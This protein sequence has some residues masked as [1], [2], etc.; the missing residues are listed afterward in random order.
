[1][2]I[3][4]KCLV[5]TALCLLLA[6]IAAAAETAESVP[7]A[8]P[9]PGRKPVI[10]IR[11]PTVAPTDTPTA[12]SDPTAAPKPTNTPAPTRTPKITNTPGPTRTPKIT[13]TPESIPTPKPTETHLPV[14]EVT[15]DEGDLTVLSIPT[16][17]PK[18][19]ETETRLEDGY[20]VS[21]N[22]ASA[23]RADELTISFV[24]DCSVGD[25]IK[26]RTNRS[27]LTQSVLTNGED[28]LFSTVSEFF[29]ADDFT[30]ANLEVVLTDRT[31]PQYPA[32]AYNMI[33][34]PSF[35]NVLK[36]GGID[37]LNTVNNHC[38]DFKYGGYEDTLKNLEE[39]GL[40]H[41]GSLNPARKTNKYLDLGRI[42]IK[43]VR[44]GLI[45]FTYPT[46][47]NLTLIAQDIQTLRDEGCQIVIVS[48]HWG[49]EEH[50]TPNSTQ[51]PYAQAV[52]DAGADVIWGHHPHVLQPVYFHDGKPIFFSTGNFV[53]GSIKNLDPASG[54]FQLTWKVQENGEVQLDHFTMIPTQIRHSKL[55]Y[56]PLV[57]TD[58]TEAK[59]CLQHVIGKAERNGFERLPDG[60]A[61]T[62]T[63]YI[64]PDGQLS[65]EKKR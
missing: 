12:A 16:P 20:L 50:K 28:W 46:N 4:A 30:L 43:G 53:F 55:E 14:L 26:S 49:R 13:N 27:S 63:V 38:I 41:F 56:R 24:G 54:I 34:Y 10:I 18:K 42:E 6:L 58:A 39:A 44:I 25:S 48:L 29:S 31:S 8:T 59:R 62:G 2:T 36:L 5:F 60:F 19:S 35:A 15:E 9:S 47:E 65:L 11:M 51:F 32:K 23:G 21:S 1:M 37:G 22:P 64:L 3:R 45:G 33:G 17:D 61:D 40:M 52:L 57:L 7:T